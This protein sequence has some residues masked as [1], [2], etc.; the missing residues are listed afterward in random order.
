MPFL[1]P[2][3]SFTFRA[4]HAAKT[5]QHAIFGLKKTIYSAGSRRPYAQGLKKH[6][7]KGTPRRTALMKQC[8]STMTSVCSN[9]LSTA[10]LE[11]KCK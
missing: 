6:S 5:Y 11:S 3:I 10:D 2:A 7:K 4:R 8:F 1:E 9:S